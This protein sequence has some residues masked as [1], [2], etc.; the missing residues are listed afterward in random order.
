MNDEIG[1]A[2]TKF[3]A[4]FINSE[5]KTIILS[6]TLKN[7]LNIGRMTKVPIKSDMVAFKSRTYDI[8]LENNYR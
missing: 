8:I 3:V 4:I 5:I 6:L 2:V 7:P 1:N